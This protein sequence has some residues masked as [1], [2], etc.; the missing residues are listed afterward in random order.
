MKSNYEQLG[1]YIRQVD[2]RNIEGK[3]ENLLGLSVQKKFIPSIAN[4]IGT[5]FSKYKVVKRGQFTYISDTSRRGDKIAIALQD[6]Y[7]EGLVSNIYTVFEITEPNKLLPE[8]LMLWFNRAEFDRY[9][10]FK[11]HGSVREIFDWD[12]LC[13]VE[14][15]I[16]SYEKQNKIVRQYRTIS[17]RI[18]LKQRINDNLA[19]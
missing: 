13:N 2:N 19:A 10:R 1:K 15:P 6:D 16:P 4:T 14:L 11:S 3:K 8:Y 12:E 5:D 9:A 17:N 18:A 7:N